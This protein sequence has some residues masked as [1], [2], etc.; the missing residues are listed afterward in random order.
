MRAD[1]LHVITAISNPVRW[2]SRIKLYQ[3]FEQHMLDSGVKLTV[4]ECAFGDRPHELGDNPH[5]NYVKVHSSG[6]NLTWNKEVL[7]NLGVSRLP[8]AKYIATID[9]DVKFRRGNWAAETVHALQHYHA[10]QPWS[11]CY[12]LGPN[13]EH[14]QAHRSFG[15]LW[16]DRKPI[17]QGPNAAP[18]GYEF[19]HPGYAWAYTRQTLDWAGGLVETAALGAADHHMAMG[20]IGR[21]GDSIHGGMTAGYKAPLNLW[22]RRVFSHVKGA[23]GYLPGTI[24]HYWH[25]SKDKRAYVSRWDILAKHQFDPMT[26]LK[27][28]SYGVLELSGNKPELAHDIDVYF[29][30]RDEDANTIS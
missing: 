1:L 5:V 25:G 18:G 24:E 4:V 3:D 2:R 13:D 7:L 9:A 16:H 30:S 23:I 17:V 20:L 29:R 10:L 28:N 6:H 11:D 8:E 26:D 15:R 21:I 19:G 27:K 14:L 12:D 22:Q